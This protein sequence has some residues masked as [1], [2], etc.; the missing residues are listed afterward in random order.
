[1]FE[2]KDSLLKYIFTIYE[3]DSISVTS[4]FNKP[5]EEENVSL[6]DVGT[7]G[8]KRIE[9]GNSSVKSSLPFKNFSNGELDER[10]QRIK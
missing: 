2:F 7:K 8:G 5:K 3:D 10:W 9:F 6:V 4:Y 1:M